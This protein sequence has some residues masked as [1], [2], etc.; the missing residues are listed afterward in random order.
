M[1]PRYSFEGWTTDGEKY[2]RKTL[3]L[4]HYLG[5]NHILRIEPPINVPKVQLFV[6]RQARKRDWK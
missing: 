1:K 4:L 3:S 6:N 2:T 5:I